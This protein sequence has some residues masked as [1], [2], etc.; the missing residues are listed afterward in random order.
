LLT[1][2]HLQSSIVLVL[3]YI[4]STHLLSGVASGTAEG[5]A[6]KKTLGW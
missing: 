2:R 1:F 4:A 3:H 5:P 6:S